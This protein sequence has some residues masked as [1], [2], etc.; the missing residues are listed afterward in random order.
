MSFVL[1]LDSQGAAVVSKVST[2]PAT[3]RPAPITVK[4]EQIARDGG[5]IVDGIN[6]SAFETWLEVS[7][8]DQGLPPDVQGA[9]ADVEGVVTGSQSN[10]DVTPGSRIGQAISG[11]GAWILSGLGTPPGSVISSSGR[12]PPGATAPGDMT[13]GGGNGRQNST[14]VAFTGIAAREGLSVSLYGLLIGLVVSTLP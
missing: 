6:I 7:T 11:I 3:S 5:I 14:V 12:K 4:P 9:S 8:F 2:G 1:S 10:G 13:M